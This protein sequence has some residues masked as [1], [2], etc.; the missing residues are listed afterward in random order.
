[1]LTLKYDV[2]W[3]K[4]NDNGDNGNGDKGNVSTVHATFS[5]AQFRGIPARRG[6]LKATSV[7]KSS[8]LFTCQGGMKFCAQNSAAILPTDLSLA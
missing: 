5:R 4:N 1:M 3:L 8:S 7:S 6:V 2:M